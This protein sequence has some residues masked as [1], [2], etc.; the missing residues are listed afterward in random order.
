VLGLCVCGEVPS[1]VAGVLSLTTCLQDRQLACALSCLLLLCSLVV[2]LQVSFCACL[3]FT[4][5]LHPAVLEFMPALMFCCTGLQLAVSIQPL[6]NSCQF[7]C[8][9]TVQCMC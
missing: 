8:L 1:S 9:K 2:C 6:C 5:C 3:L 7:L 4:A